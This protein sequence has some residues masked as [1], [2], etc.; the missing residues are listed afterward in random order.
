MMWI[1]LPLFVTAG[2]R[3]GKFDATNIKYDKN[4][5]IV[6]C[7]VIHLLS[8]VVYLLIKV[9]S[10]QDQVSISVRFQVSFS[11]FVVHL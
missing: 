3:K 8:N 2:E 5:I 9:G 10:N 6:S 4:H 7:V 11:A 1:F